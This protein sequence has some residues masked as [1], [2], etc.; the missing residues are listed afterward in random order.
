MNDSYQE[1]K[2][3]Y[4]DLPKTFVHFL[5]EIKILFRAREKH[6]EFLIQNCLD[7]LSKKIS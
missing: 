5:T 6:E 2:P 1:P 3:K 7:S 4:G